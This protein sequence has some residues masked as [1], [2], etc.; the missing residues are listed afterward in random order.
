MRPHYATADVLIDKWIM[1]NAWNPMSVSA[2]E[3]ARADRDLKEAGFPH[4]VREEVDLPH[5]ARCRQWIVF[6]YKTAYQAIEHRR[7]AAERRSAA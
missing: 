7:R 5:T 6:G 2:A 4:T 3:F 1:G